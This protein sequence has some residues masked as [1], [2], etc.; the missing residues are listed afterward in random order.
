MDV[1]DVIALLLA[2]ALLRNENFLVGFLI[3]Y[4]VLLV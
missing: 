1:I 3:I 2:G 4:I